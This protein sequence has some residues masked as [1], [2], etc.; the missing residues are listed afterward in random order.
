M[1]ISNVNQITSIINELLEMSESESE[2]AQLADADKVDVLCNTL[3]RTV[4]R[5]SEGRQRGDV[6]LRF[7]SNVD[8]EFTIRS[9]SYRLKSALTHLV[10]NAIKFT[11]SGYVEVRC[12][13]L[14]DKMQFLVTDT[15]VGIK[16]SDKERIFET[17]AKVDDF[18]EGIGLGLP[19]CRRLIRSLGGEVTLDTTYT[20]GCR[21]VISLP[22]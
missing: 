14:G 22:M 20:G 1:R 19:I 7:A 21:F 8:D 9:S 17:F 15:G 4:L 16:E 18:K 11:D 12:E 3:A 6:E 13:Q 5:E 2:G 10:D